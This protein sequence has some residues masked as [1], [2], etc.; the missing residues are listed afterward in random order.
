MRAEV[1]RNV[2]PLPWRDIRAL[3]RVRCPFYRLHNLDELSVERHGE[4]SGNFKDGRITPV[5]VHPHGDAVDLG[6]TRHNKAMRDITPHA[7]RRKI[8]HCSAH[9]NWHLSLATCVHSATSGDT[10]T[11]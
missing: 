3:Q 2:V 6:S 4:E 11:S 7:Q 5:P 1:H 9:N 8:A 10:P